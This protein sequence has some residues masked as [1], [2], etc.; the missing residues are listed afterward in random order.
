MDLVLRKRQTGDSSSSSS[1]LSQPSTSSSTIGGGSL[2]HEFQHDF[3]EFPDMPHGRVNRGD[4][5]LPGVQRDVRLA[6]SRAAAFF[7]KH[8]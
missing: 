5:R 4:L 3:G 2:E 8:L 1:S 7:D 6:L